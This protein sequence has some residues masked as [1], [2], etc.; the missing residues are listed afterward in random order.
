[1]VLPFTA[2]HFNLFFFVFATATIAFATIVFGDQ[3]MLRSIPLAGFVTGGI[4]EAIAVTVIGFECLPVQVRAQP[5]V[6]EH[7]SPAVRTA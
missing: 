1:M 6:F 2:V 3:I 5:Q 4:G 7:F